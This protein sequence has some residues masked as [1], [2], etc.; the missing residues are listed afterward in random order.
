[1]QTGVAG[2]RSMPSATVG[3]RFNG[4]RQIDD[5]PVKVAH[6]VVNKPPIAEGNR[7]T[8]VASDRASQIGNGTLMVALVVV[9]QRP[10][11]EGDA[12]VLRHRALARERAS[13]EGVLTMLMRRPTGNYA[14][15]RDSDISLV[16][17]R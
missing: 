16:F 8:R 17:R 15:R 3:R 9:S 12:L 1:M 13:K 14:V 2:H 4:S 10:I 6:V 7:V 11:A 5:G